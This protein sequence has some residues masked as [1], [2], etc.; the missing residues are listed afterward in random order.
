LKY[1]TTGDGILFF[2]GE[3]DGGDGDGF[4]C[5]AWTTAAGRRG[6][7]V[8]LGG[9]KVAEA[10]TAGV[11]WR[12]AQRRRWG[13]HVFSC[14]GEHGG[15]GRDGMYFLKF[16]K[17]GGFSFLAAARRRLNGIDDEIFEQADFSS[18]FLIVTETTIA[19]FRRDLL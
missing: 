13:R 15:G 9:T 10:R 4:F 12:G 17:V 18:A 3:H 1:E 8:F 5:L 19:N 14:G 7:Q 11:F 6:R 2:G 16:G